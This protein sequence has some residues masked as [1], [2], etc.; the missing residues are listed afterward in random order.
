MLNNR[1]NISVGDRF[2]K[3]EVIEPAPD[4]KHGNACWK[5]KCECGTVAIVEASNLRAGRSRQCLNC[6]GNLKYDE[7]QIGQKFGSWEVLG[8]ADT[9]RPGTWWN[10]RCGCGVELNLPNGHLMSGRATRCR[11]CANEKGINLIGQTFNKWTVIGRIPRAKNRKKQPWICQCVCG[12]TQNL[13]RSSLVKGESKGCKRCQEN[14]AVRI[15]P[16]EGLF[17]ALRNHCTQKAKAADGY[18]GSILNLVYEEFLVLTSVTQCH[19]CF[20]PIQW[21]KFN[22]KKHG[23]HYNLDRKD[24]NQGYSASNVVVACRRCNFGKGDRYTY[25]QWHEMTE[26]FRRGD[27][28]KPQPPTHA[29]DAKRMVSELAELGVLT[30]TVQ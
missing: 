3:W 24:N 2:T 4:D 6:A 25:K 20:A 29:A 15:R 27:F 5:C 13:T 1:Q 19:Y 11:L 18:A 12:N 16:F 17:N 8:R 9:E 21:T 30:K 10:C 22:T 7:P 14:T 26:C 28:T 23:A